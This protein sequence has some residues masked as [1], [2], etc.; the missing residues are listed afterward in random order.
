MFRRALIL[1]LGGVPVSDAIEA[2]CYER[3]RPSGKREDLLSPAAL[4]VWQRAN[5]INA[6][7]R[8]LGL[9]R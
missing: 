5:K 9:G 2:V 1:L 8:S 3:Q 6:E 7:A 4:V